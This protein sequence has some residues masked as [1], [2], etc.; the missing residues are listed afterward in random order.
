M[1]G[2]NP[3]TYELTVTNADGCDTTVIFIVQNMASLHEENGIGLMIYPN[4]SE[5]IFVISYEALTEDLE[6][7]VSDA[8]G[9]IVRV[10][11]VAVSQF[12]EHY[13]LDL[14]KLEPGSYD[15]SIKSNEITTVKRLIIQ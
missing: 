14:S 6:L 15:L 8:G 13:A 3:G 1:N 7:R 2:I 9:R 11:N 4:P 5:G 12:P 10:L